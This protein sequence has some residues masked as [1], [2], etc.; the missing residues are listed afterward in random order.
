[1]ITVIT[2]TTTDVLN[3]L[4]FVACWKFRALTDDA[5][6]VNE[7]PWIIDHKINNMPRAVGM[8]LLSP[9]NMPFS[10][11]MVLIRRNT[12]SAMAKGNRQILNLIMFETTND[13]S[14]SDEF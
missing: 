10:P 2:V 12:T 4:D 7:L 6:W 14:L 9:G 11:A 13:C 5:H 8:R 3:V 1:M